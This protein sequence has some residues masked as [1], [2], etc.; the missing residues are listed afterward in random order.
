[1]HLKYKYLDLKYKNYVLNMS[2]TIYVY[3]NLRWGIIFVLR[4]RGDS[5]SWG[6]VSG[7]RLQ[8]SVDF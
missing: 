8:C 7:V 1:M 6:G 5:L 4:Q 2:I 3:E